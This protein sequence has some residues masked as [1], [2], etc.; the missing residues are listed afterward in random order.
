MLDV[1]YLGVVNNLMDYL[2]FMTKLAKRQSSPGAW[3]LAAS[4]PTG[5]VVGNC[6]IRQHLDL[7][8]SRR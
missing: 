8:S 2:A 5:N 7:H 1:D 4:R 3:Y 6:E